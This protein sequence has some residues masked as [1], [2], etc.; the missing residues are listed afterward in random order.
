M[1]PSL[2]Q[3]RNQQRSESY[4]RSL[5]Q[6]TGVQS[7]F[8]FYGDTLCRLNRPLSHFICTDDTTDCPT[9]PCLS[10][11]HTQI[12]KSFGS[13]ESPPA[14]PYPN[15]FWPLSQLSSAADGDA[16]V[17]RRRLSTAATPKDRTQTRDRTQTDTA[18][19]FGRGAMYST[20]LAP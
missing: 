16:L 13:S 19:L 18:M 3:T 15:V 12:T 14:H 10:K 5:Q 20:L 8:P 11:D 4:T 6:V 2:L 7:H 9:E 17:A 1:L